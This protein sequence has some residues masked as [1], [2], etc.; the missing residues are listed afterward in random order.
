[1]LEKDMYDSWKSIME[2]YMMNRQHERMILESVQNGSLIWPTIEENSVTRP[3]KYTKL[4]PTK[5]IQADCDV[6]ATNIIL[7]GL[8][9]EVYTLLHAYLGQHEFHA[10][11]VRLMHE[12]NS[13]PLAM[14]ATYQMTNSGLTVPLFKKGDNPIDSI[15]R[16]M[17]FLSVVVTSRY[18]TTNNRLRNSSNPRQQATIN[19]ERVTL[20]L[21]QGRQI[22]FATGTTRTYTLGASGSNFRKQRTVICYNS[23]GEGHMSKQCTKPKRKRDDSWFKDKVLLVQAQANGQIIHEEELAFL[24]D[25]GIIEAN[26]AHYGSDALAEFGNDHVAKI[27]GY[28]DYQIGWHLSKTFVARSPQQNGVVEIRNRTLIEVFRTR[29]IYSKA[30]LFLWAEAVATACYTQNSSIICLH[31]GKTSYE[32]LHDKLPELSF[33]H[34]F[35]A[36]CY[37]TNNSENLGKLQSKADIGI[38]IGYEPTKKEF[39]IYNRGIRRIIETIHEDFVELATMAS[40]HSS[41]EPALHEM[42]PTTISLGFVLNPPLST[43]YVPPLRTNWDI[44]FQLLFDELLTPSPSVDLPAPEVIAPIVE[45]VAPKHAAS[46]GSPSSTI[47][48]QDDPSP[49]NSQTSPETQS[50]VIS[51][52]VKEESHDLNVAYM[53]NDP[54]PDGF[55]DKYN[56]NHVYKLKALYGLKQAPRVCD[57][58]NTPM[59][60]KSKLDEDPQG[61]A[62]DPT[63]YR[64]MVGTLILSATFKP[65]EPTFQIALDVL[66]F[67]PFYQAFLISTSVPAIY[68][69]ELW[70]TFSFHKQCIKFKLNK[71]NHSFDL[72]TFRVMLQICPNLP[73]QKFVDPLFKEKILAFIIKLSYFRDIKS[74]SDVKVDTLHQPWRTCRTI[75]N[76][77]LSGKVIGLYQLRLSRAQIIWGM[78]Y[79]NN[80]D[81]V[82]LLWE[83]LVYQIKNK[84]SKKK[85]DMYYPKFTKVIINHFMSKDQSIPRRNKVDWH[86]AN[87]YLILT[88]MRFIPKHETVQKY[89]SILPDTLTN[90]AMNE[91]DAYKTYYDFA[92]RKVIPKPKYVQ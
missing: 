82:Y 13:D 22:S 58:V 6:K 18:P 55:V 83:D 34:V 23:K 8:P 44:L 25:P 80:V 28:S 40:K 78:Y 30:P 26:L 15:N 70:A 19:D 5:A 75:I 61:K 73:G 56:S 62:V 88:T 2:L 77:C 57:P 10:N 38:F 4:T 33:F 48:D 85:K 74:L 47:V 59:V 49:S 92:T 11:E 66:S 46:T 63:H 16:M 29:L 50:P 54:Q 3:R 39:R 1:M 84:V 68:M 76:K 43:L 12:R 79:Q 64:R 45:V 60:E 89:V 24:A 53:N 91:S 52:D 14:V 31:H 69:H 36:L 42:T 9:P 41:L 32:L 27:L 87:D 72:E 37:L 17:S 21:V 20:Q 65:K 86:M 51:N 81:Y 7:Q 67:T 71:K 90:Q 35:G